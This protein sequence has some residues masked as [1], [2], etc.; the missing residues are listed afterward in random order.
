MIYAF[1]NMLRIILMNE[2]IENKKVRDKNTN[3]L[4]ERLM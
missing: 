4:Q 1:I 2:S 3:Y